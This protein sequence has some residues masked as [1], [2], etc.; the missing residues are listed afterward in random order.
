LAT[1]HKNK[2]HYT[3]KTKKLTLV[4]ISP[5]RQQGPENQGRQIAEKHQKNSNGRRPL[6][7]LPPFAQTLTQKGNGKNSIE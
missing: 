2:F 5:V 7:V 4:T 3:K 6:I 1:L